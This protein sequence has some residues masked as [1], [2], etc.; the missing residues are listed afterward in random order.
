MNTSDDDLELQELKS[1]RSVTDTSGEL[2]TLADVLTSQEAKIDWLVE[3]L[4]IEGGTSLLAAKPK[5]G[6]TTFSRALAFSVATESLFI[7]LACKRASVLMIVLEDKITE[8]GRH[9]RQM[10]AQPEAKILFLTKAPR[11]AKALLSIIQKHQIG[12]VIIDTL[13]LGVSGIHDINDYLQTSRSL[14]PYVQLAR[15]TGCHI[16][17]THHLGK[18]DRSGG[19]QILGSTGLFGS[20]DSVL[21]LDRQKQVRTFSTIMRYGADW[22][23]AY[24]TLGENGAVTLDNEVDKDFEIQKQILGCLKKSENSLTEK[25]LEELVYGRTADKRKTL[26]NLVS[27]NLILRE[28]SGSKTS[29]YKYSFVN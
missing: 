11:N 23:K 18:Q 12:F 29:P 10:G 8:V 4:L 19:D 3:N 27:Q 6:K 2:K 9:F 17:F 16:M 25:Q 5:V 1:Q 24:L 13:V 22:P 15:D 20:V 21:I 7:G 28:G 14:S 26:R